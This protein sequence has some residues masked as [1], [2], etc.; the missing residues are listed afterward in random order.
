MKIHIMLL[1]AV[2]SFGTACKSKKE[3]ASTNKETKAAI[4]KITGKVSHQYRASG[5]ATVVITANPDGGEE[6][7]LIPSVKLAS[8]FDVDGLQIS[9]DYI[10]LRMPQPEGCTKGVPA[11]FSNI[12]KK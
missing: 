6:L 7:T 1:A 12:S 8:E 3:V 4:G 10:T 2:L 5:C 9:F 11:E